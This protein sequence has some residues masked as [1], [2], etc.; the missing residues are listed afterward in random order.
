MSIKERSL[1]D[2]G[3]NLLALQRSV[4]FGR[5]LLKSIDVVSFTYRILSKALND[6]GLPL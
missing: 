4:H 6:G 5:S 3:R 2:K 1:Y